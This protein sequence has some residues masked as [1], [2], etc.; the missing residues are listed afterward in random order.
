MLSSIS[1][2]SKHEFVELMEGMNFQQNLDIYKI[3][4]DNFFL[5]GFYLE[6]GKL[7]CFME[8]YDKSL[9]HTGSIAGLLHLLIMSTLSETSIIVVNYN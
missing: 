2:N 9:L 1:C 5:L 6:F 7:T 8:S 3:S 4:L